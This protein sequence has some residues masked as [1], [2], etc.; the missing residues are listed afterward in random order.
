M[1]QIIPTSDSFGQL[2]TDD[3]NLAGFT[4]PNLAAGYLPF[5]AA[6]SGYIPLRFPSFSNTVGGNT[7]VIVQSAVDRLPALYDTYSVTTP[8]I[9]RVASFVEASISSL[10]FNSPSYRVGAALWRAAYPSDSQTNALFRCKMLAGLPGKRAFKFCGV[11]ARARNQT[12]VTVIS[13]TAKGQH[14]K[15]DGDF[16]AFCLLND[17]SVGNAWRFYLLR[18][19]S[20][21]FTV[22]N[23]AAIGGFFSNVS[24][25]TFSS[26][27]IGLELSVTGSGATVTLL[28]KASIGSTVA[29]VFNHADTDGARLTTPGRNGIMMG[30]YDDTGDSPL[31]GELSGQRSAHVCSYWKVKDLGTGSVLVRDEWDRNNSNVG[32][33]YK[34][35]DK[36]GNAGQSLMPIYGGDCFASITSIARPHRR[37]FDSSGYLHNTPSDN[38]NYGWSL[39]KC[40]SQAASDRAMQFSYD[41]SNADATSRDIDATIMV[42]GRF[43]NPGASN[44]AYLVRDFYKF[45]FKVDQGAGNDILCYLSHI[46]SNG[47]SNQLSVTTA[48]PIANWGLGSS[49]TMKIRLKVTNGS[50]IDPLA[51]QTRLQCYRDTGSGWVLITEWITPTLPGVSSDGAGTFTDSR[52]NRPVTGWHEG[53]LLSLMQTGG[54]IVPT[55]YSLRMLEWTDLFVGNNT[56]GGTSA[57]TRAVYPGPEPLAD[58]PEGE[59]SEFDHATIALN[60]ECVGK[61]G[62]LTVPYD[63]GVQEQAKAEAIIAPFEAGYRVR[64]VRHTRQRRRWTIRANAITD[65]ERTT[66]LNFWTS[67]KG[68][69][70]PFDWA[71]PETGATVAVRFADDSLAVTLANPAVRQF[72]FVLEEVFC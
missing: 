59:L 57:G 55:P 17:L 53:W 15:Q 32:D 30:T 38:F 21:S 66:L 28:A 58:D 33:M 44:Y 47:S 9:S 5:R 41:L 64:S 65:S 8:N 46:D 1:A 31:S 24:G 52:S 27:G 2:T 20:G 56:P 40:K 61:T 72:E 63:W 36:N 69:E 12:D 3:A 62:T 14:G 34:I 18:C 54:S 26:T 6:A 13:Q 51:A 23:S 43:F 60:S 71:D 16:Y 35:T 70:I 50:T 4:N 10:A 67:H 48:I 39:F 37:T 19:V 49:N 7:Y 45:T 68:A 11:I 25:S 22:L 42:R 29:T